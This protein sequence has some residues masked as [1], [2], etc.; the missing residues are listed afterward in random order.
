ME[1]SF[2]RTDS[3][4]N[5]YLTLQDFEHGWVD[6]IQ[7]SIPADSSLIQKLRDATLEYWGHVLKPGDQ[8]TKEQF[9]ERMAEFGALEKTRHDEGK[10]PMVFKMVNAMFDVVDTNHDGCLTLDEYEKLLVAIN[11][12]TGTAKIVYDAIDTNHNDKLSRQILLEYNYS[13]WFTLDL[14][15]RKSE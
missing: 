4:H 14:K 8:L 7:K 1:K 10:D 6:S 9:V 13:F 5:N 2:A 3:N 15:V 11:F 12:P